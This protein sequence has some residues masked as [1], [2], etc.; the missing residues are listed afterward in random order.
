MCIWYE[1]FHILLILLQARNMLSITS[2][3]LNKSY[4]ISTL[5]LKIISPAIPDTFIDS[6]SFPK[7]RTKIFQL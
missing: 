6:L 5:F 7:A 4:H 2:I 1:S 3:E